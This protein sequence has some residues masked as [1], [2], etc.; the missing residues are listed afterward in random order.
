MPGLGVICTV[1][2]WPKATRVAI[3]NR[4]LMAEEG[5]GGV[6]GSVQR[7]M[8]AAESEGCTVVC[9]AANGVLALPLVGIHYACLLGCSL[10]CGPSPSQLG[11]ACLAPAM[12]LRYTCCYRPDMHRPVRRNSGCQRRD[13]A[14]GPRDRRGA[15]STW[16]V[17]LDPHGR[18]SAMR[19][20]CRQA[21][22]CR[23][24]SCTG[25]GTAGWEARAD[26]DAAGARRGGLYDWGWRE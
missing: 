25:G 9:I 8:N 16:Q 6:D 10:G 14:R 7:S 23:A 24:G 26:S 22:R 12:N 18:Q 3:G 17:N 1:R 21:A 5:V 4:A 20:C 2:T 19:C 11:I 13:Q 15:A